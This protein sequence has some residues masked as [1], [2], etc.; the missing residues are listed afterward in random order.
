MRLSSAGDLMIYRSRYLDRM[1]FSPLGYRHDARSPHAKRTRLPTQSPTQPRAQLQ[2]QSYTQPPYTQP[3]SDEPVSYYSQAY[4]PSSP[5]P[6]YGY[7]AQAG[8]QLGH[9]G[10]R[11]SYLSSRE[12][13]LIVGRCEETIRGGRAQIED[14]EAFV[15]CQQE[16]SSRT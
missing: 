16:L 5:Q 12:L 11:A 14:Y 13:R 7:Q 1:L 8:Q 15:I 3:R 9:L 2:A 10:E 4:Q 6:S